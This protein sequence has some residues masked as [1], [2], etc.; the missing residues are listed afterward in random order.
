MK[1][2]FFKMT[3]AALTLACIGSSSFADK[4]TFSGVLGN[5]GEQGKYL[6]RFGAKQARGLGVVYDKYGSLWDRGGDGVLNRYALDGRLLAS[7]PIP[8]GERGSEKITA[9][10]DKIVLL[11]QGKLYT[12]P[13][14][15]PA[16]TKPTPLGIDADEMSFGSYDGKIAISQVK[17]IPD[18]AG[19]KRVSQISYLNLASKEIVSAAKSALA[20]ARSIELLSNGDVVVAVQNK[21]QLLHNGEK[22]LETWPRPSP[23]GRHQF[24]DG[25]WFGQNYH[26]T[27]RRF[28]AEFEAEPG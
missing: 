11:L 4:L 21:M 22:T 1:N 5:S 6:V 13:V 25:F 28:N 26:G 23:G 14:D 17:E 3:A 18:G 12:L 15:S 16:G 24:L 9:V 2:T 8:A 27:V 7:Y 10:G 19:K 20:D